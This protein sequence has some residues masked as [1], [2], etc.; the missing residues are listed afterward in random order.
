MAREK[1]KWTV[2]VYF[3]AD[4]DLDE[5]AP[6]NLEQMKKVGSSAE[7]NLIAE[8]DRRG[9]KPPKR[10]YLRPEREG[11]L[12]HDEVKPA[13]SERNTGDPQHLIEFIEWAAKDFPADHYMLVLWGHGK[14]W[15][16]DVDCIV[17]SLG[18]SSF[19]PLGSFADFNP[20]D[21][22]TNPEL[23]HALATGSKRLGQKIDI[24]G[25]DAC[26]MNMVEVS[27]QLQESVSILVG[28]E[29][30]SP[31]EG[32]PYDSILSK[33]IES[34]EMPPERLAAIAVEEYAAHYRKVKEE[35][36]DKKAED[37]KLSKD[38]MLSA[39]DLSKS[40]DLAE[41]VWKLAVALRAGLADGDAKA[42][43]MLARR[44]ARSY[45][46]NEYVDLCN[47]C[48]HL[49]A[50]SDDRLL[51]Q[52]CEEVIDVIR[53]RRFVFASASTEEEPPDGRPR[54]SNGVSI[55]LPAIPPCYNDIDFV[56]QTR[57]GEFLDLFLNAALF[58]RW[59]IPGKEKEQIMSDYKY[60]SSIYRTL[61]ILLDAASAANRPHRRFSA[62]GEEAEYRYPSSIYRLF[63]DLLLQAERS[64]RQSPSRPDADDE[65]V[66][67]V[68]IKVRRD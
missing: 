41:A 38:V 14:G 19:A 3:A 39:C 35:E 33:L 12:C 49:F 55:Y 27:H 7:V 50:A 57:W 13:L 30:V 24:L 22:L 25:L 36:K 26:L 48:E 21:F 4:N 43:I 11:A 2:M 51:K 68:R 44:R 18:Q 5:Y 63:E 8:L 66:L 56:E 47:F 6:Q 46:V 52:A 9:D 60:P 45:F 65:I 42:T 17:K 40:D 23:R 28:S 54:P 59:H 61:D 64:S 58:T 62:G 32:W 31:K 53:N 1:K 34:P 67:E 29:E 37:K 15:D 10:Y 20:P 16:D